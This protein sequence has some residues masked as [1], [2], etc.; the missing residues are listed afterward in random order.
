MN[1]IDSENIAK[2]AKLPARPNAP[3]SSERWLGG[4]QVT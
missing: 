2:P 4:N 3:V 1:T